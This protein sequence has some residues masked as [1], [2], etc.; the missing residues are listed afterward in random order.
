MP[1]VVS[2]IDG[3][4]VGITGS[5]HSLMTTVDGRVLAFGGKPPFFPPSSTTALGL[6]AGVP[7]ALTPTAIDGITIGEGDEGKEG[8]E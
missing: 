7:E 5:S 6:G 4:V 2:G 3:A 8:K 1:R